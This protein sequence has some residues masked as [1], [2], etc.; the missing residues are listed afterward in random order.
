MMGPQKTR[1]RPPT[2]AWPEVMQTHCCPRYNR[3]SPDYHPDTPSALKR[4]GPTEDKSALPDVPL[5][6][7]ISSHA[8]Q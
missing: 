6:G 8:A 3:T 7:K 1:S 5:L 2:S 4:F